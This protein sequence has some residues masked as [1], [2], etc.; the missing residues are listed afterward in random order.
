MPEGTRLDEGQ[1]TTITFGNAANLGIWE[2]ET[3]P[4]G[5]DGGDPVATSTHRNVTWDTF[6]PRVLKTLSAANCTG[7]YAAGK[8]ANIYQ[9]VN[10]NQIITVTF[11]N[12]A[13]IAFWGYLRSFQ[14]EP[15]VEGQQPRAS[16]SIQPTNQNMSNVETGPTFT[17]EST[18]TVTTTTTI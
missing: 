8:L 9:Q 5:V 18:T 10:R 11:R 7:A 3:Q 6:N 14:P 12:G 1:G 2:V 4:A 17:I 16:F 15:L 13:T